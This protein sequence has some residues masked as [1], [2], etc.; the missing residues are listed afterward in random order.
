MSTHT[1]GHREYIIVGENKIRKIMRESRIMKEIM[2][3]ASSQK[4]RLWRNNVGMAWT[5]NVIRI[6]SNEILIKNPRPFYAGLCKYSSDLIGFT[7]VN[8]I[9]VFTAVET[10]DKKGKASK[11]QKDFIQMINNLN[12]ISFIARSNEQYIKEIDSWKKKNQNLFI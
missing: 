8:G 6:N 12:G 2:L 4:N 5:G 1:H 11:G 7:N 9:A 10:K 3:L